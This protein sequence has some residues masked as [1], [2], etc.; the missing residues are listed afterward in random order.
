MGVS[1]SGKTTLGKLLSINTGIPFLDADNF[2][3]QSNIQ[4]MNAGIALNDNDRHPWLENLSIKLS[5]Q[6]KTDGAILACSALKEAYREI[7]TSKL[8]TEILWIFLNGDKSMILDRMK[9]RKDHFMPQSLLDSQFE[10]LQIP[11]NAINI[12]IDQS[13]EQIVEKIQTHI[14]NV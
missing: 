13:P 5:E 3:P 12:D 1:G 14:R 6:E 8:K 11:S 9:N 10:T 4:K 2:H 7:L